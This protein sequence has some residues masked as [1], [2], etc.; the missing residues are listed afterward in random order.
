MD[1]W[2]EEGAHGAHF[3]VD[4]LSCSAR[5]MQLAAKKFAAAAKEAKLEH[6]IWSTSV[7]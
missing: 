6:V 4:S 1:G 3:T 7:P 2:T 5:G